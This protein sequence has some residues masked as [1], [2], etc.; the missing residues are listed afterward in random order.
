MTPL[1][2]IGPPH[3]CSWGPCILGAW[4][5]LGGGQTEGLWFYHVE[6]EQ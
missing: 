2:T 6:L 5:E 3:A 4:G 1:G